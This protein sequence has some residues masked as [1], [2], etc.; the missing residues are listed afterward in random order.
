M[1]VI[2]GGRV[3]PGFTRNA[4]N[5][6][7]YRGKLPT[8]NPYADKLAIITAVLL[9]LFVGLDAPA[10]VV[11]VAAVVAAICN[12]VRLMGWRSL[13]VRRE[14]I[15]W[16]LHLAFALLVLGFAVLAI[17]HLGNVVSEIAALH[18]LGI[19]AVGGMTLAMMTR[20]SLG[21]TGRALIVARP[22]AAAYAMI[23][24]AAVLRTFGATVFPSA[25][26][27]VMFVAGG[28]WIA[29]FVIFV[30]FYVPVLC[31]ERETR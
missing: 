28:L 31:V 23:A 15:L 3:I 21:H 1:I 8:L 18:L 16:S 26:Y 14:P 17:A 30:W 10:P 29:G 19:G 12:G 20:A 4:L 27:E 9:A 11:G 6:R 7:G 25:Y 24:A 5:K 13:T 2:I 22:I